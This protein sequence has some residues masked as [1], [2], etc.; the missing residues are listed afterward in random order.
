LRDNKEISLR[1]NGVGT[2]IGNAAKAGNSLIHITEVYKRM[3]SKDEKAGTVT[4]EDQGR[5]VFGRLAV[6]R[7]EW[8]P[9]GGW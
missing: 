2:L 9:D 8:A 3:V 1:L 5:A 6:Q 7:K 4:W